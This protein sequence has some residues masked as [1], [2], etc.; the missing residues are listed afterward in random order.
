MTIQQ[1]RYVVE[2]EACGSITEAAK[3]LFVS[4]PGMSV[5]IRELEAELNINLF[6]RSSRG[7]TT[8]SEGE[9]FLGHARQIL[10][11]LDLVRAKYIDSA[12]QKQRFSVSTHHYA[13]AADAFVELVKK[14]GGQEHGSQEYE[15]SLRE[16]QTREIIDD[17]KNMRSEVGIL[18]I[19]RLNQRVIRKLL[20]NSDLVFYE[21][22]AVQPHVFI[23]RGNPLSARASLTLEELEALPYLSYEQR[24]GDSFYFAEEVLNI[25]LFK[26]R[27]TVTDRAAILDL[28]IGLGGF[29]IGSGVLPTLLHRQD[30]VSVP[31]VSEE[32]MRVGAITNRDYI[33]TRLGVIYMETLREIGKVVSTGRG[34]GAAQE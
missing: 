21:L 19:S 33:P 14:Y 18:H 1:L 8:T 31:L 7:I 24:G 20:K 3:R 9:A 23:S 28:M 34:S 30:I 6:V 13:F 10:Q 4:Q 17:V 16:T 26:K 25:P 22:F 32:V 2:A 29:T 5:A 11:Q 27:I 12:P 15:F